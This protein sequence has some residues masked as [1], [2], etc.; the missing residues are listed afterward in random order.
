MIKGLIP[1]THANYVC[2]DG[3]RMKQ[4]AV[5]WA[6]F[7]PMLECQMC[8]TKLPVSLSMELLGLWPVLQR[9]EVRVCVCC[10]CVCTQTVLIHPKMSNYYIYVVLTASVEG[11]GLNAK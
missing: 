10:V 2:V 1:P 9:S 5:G 11:Y 8:Q 4:N 6:T 7:L 3:G